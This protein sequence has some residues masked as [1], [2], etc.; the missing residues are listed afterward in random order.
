MNY[1]YTPAKVGDI[2]FGLLDCIEISTG[3]PTF[4]KILMAIKYVML[5]REAGFITLSNLAGDPYYARSLFS[6]NSLTNLAMG[7]PIQ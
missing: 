4:N 3:T 5:Q 1:S 7:W 2:S 6:W